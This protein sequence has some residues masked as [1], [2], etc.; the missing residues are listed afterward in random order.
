MNVLPLFVHGLELTT[1]A[2]SA[3]T[4]GLHQAGIDYLYLLDR[5]YPRQASLHLVGNRYQLDRHGRAV[6]QRGIFPRRQAMQRRHKL[7]TIQEVVG[8]RLLI[9]GH[10]VLITIESALQARLLVRG[11]D[12]LLRDVAGASRG[13]RPSSTTDTAISMLFGLL[14]HHPPDEIHFY[15][16]APMSRSGELAARLRRRLQ[17]HHFQGSA[18]AVAVPERFLA[19][20]T[21]IVASSDSVVVDRA[22]MA[23]DLAAAV[24]SRF[25]CQAR[26]VDFSHLLHGQ[27]MA[28]VQPE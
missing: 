24:V 27:A 25:D 26:F 6:L 20:A 10:N 21:A 15:L 1:M 9:D 14:G 18:A 16:D 19:D 4:T 13:Y 3:A 12:G 22:T 11:N 5:G 8:S 23:V 2:G 28:P 7:V 17:R